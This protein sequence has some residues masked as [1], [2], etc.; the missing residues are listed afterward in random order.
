[1]FAEKI[2]ACCAGSSN[3]SPPPNAMPGSGCPGRR[4]VAIA[5]ADDRFDEIL[6]AR[7]GRRPR[8]RG[9]CVVSG[10][11]IVFTMKLSGKM[12]FVRRHRVLDRRDG[13]EVHDDRREILVGEVPESH[14]G[15]DR[16]QRAAVLVHA[17]LNRARDL[18]VGPVADAGLGIRRDVRRDHVAEL[19]ASAVPGPALSCPPPSACR[20]GQI[21]LGVAMETAGLRFDDVL[22]ALEAGRR[23]LEFAARHGP[24]LRAQDHLPADFRDDSDHRHQDQCQHA[25]KDVRARTFMSYPPPERRRTPPR[26]ALPSDDPRGDPDDNPTLPQVL[27]SAFAAACWSSWRLRAPALAQRGSP[28]PMDEVVQAR[29]GRQLRNPQHERPHGDPHRRFGRRRCRRGPH[30]SALAAMKAREKRCAAWK[31]AETVSPDHVLLDSTG[32]GMSCKSTSPRRWTSS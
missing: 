17:L 32:G 19:R 4:R 20:V 13:S 23:D 25:E 14:V 6:A 9:A 7:F 5:A 21:V 30:P 29:A 15:H 8:G 10:A 24:G 3:I 16:E 11:G 26:R 2:A 1:M 28:R 18:V 31:S 12:S 27:G 22:A